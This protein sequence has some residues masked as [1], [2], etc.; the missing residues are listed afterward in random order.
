MPKFKRIL[1]SQEESTHTRLCAICDEW[2]SV[3]FPKV[4]VA[5]VFS[6][7]GS[8]I[9]D[10]HY[11]YALQAHFDFVI[12]T[13]D[14]KPLFAVEFDGPTHSHEEQIRRDSIKDSLCERFELPILRIN[15]NYLPKKYRQWDLL[16]WFVEYWFLSEAFSQAQR[17]GDIPPD[18]GFDV[19]SAYRIPGKDGR[20][21][22]SLSLDA[23]AEMLEMSQQGTISDPIPS[24]QVARDGSRF[25]RA[26]AFL[27]VTSDTA[28]VATT[29]MRAQS[30][31]VGA[32]EV[33][34]ELVILDLYDAL[35]E[36]LAGTQ[37]PIEI[38]EA[39]QRFR[40]FQRRYE[41]CWGGGFC[42]AHGMNTENGHET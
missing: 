32:F 41:F 20:F 26:I 29:G 35:L 30:F 21:P 2:G 39:E 17:R 33:L 27:R 22:L 13:D 16:S 8:G 1:N 12:T 6:I 24:Y 38:A 14:H 36:V 31:P 5:D 9:S 18:E 34:D 3:V 42:R 25:Y 19:L 23:R 15:A 4:R 11:R 28:V 7:E 37:S 10:S 40:V